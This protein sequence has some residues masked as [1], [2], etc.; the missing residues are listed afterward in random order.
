[1]DALRSRGRYVAMVGDG[2]NDVISLKRANLGIA[3][4]SGSQAA[5]G[6]ADMVLLNDS[7]GSLPFAFQEG[8]RI[9]NG[10]ADILKI[11]MV[12]IFSKVLIIASVM[13]VGGFPFS[14]A[15]GFH[16]LV[17]H[18]RPAHACLRRVGPARGAG[19]QRPGGDGWSDS[20]YRPVL[21]QSLMALAVYL[22]YFIPRERAFL[23]AD[24]LATRAEALQYVLPSAQTATDSVRGRCADCS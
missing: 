22:L 24:P 1:M 6:V 18:R 19:A 4:Q 2:V 16:A 8:Q 21:L 5:R 17:L 9:Q 23:L 12:R 15:A 13:A 11:F 3:M 7:F 14:P 20:H 10:M